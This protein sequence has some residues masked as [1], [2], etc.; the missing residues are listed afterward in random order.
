MVELH[1]G[2]IEADGEGGKGTTMRV[3][4]PMQAG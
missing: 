1:G 2:Q 3:R 4:L